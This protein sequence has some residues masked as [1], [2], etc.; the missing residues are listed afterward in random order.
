MGLLVVIEGCIGLYGLMWVIEVH[1]RSLGV[2]GVYN[3]LMGIWKAYAFIVVHTG[4]VV[5]YL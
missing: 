1:R 4:I 2:N 3:R 5:I